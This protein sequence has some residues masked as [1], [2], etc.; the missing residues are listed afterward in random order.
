MAIVAACVAPAQAQPPPTVAPGDVGLPAAVPAGPAVDPGLIDGPPAPAAPRG[1]EPQR[2]GPHDGP[3]DSSRRGH[4]PRRR[5]RRAGLRDGAGNHRLHPAR[6]RQRGARHRADRGVDHVRRDERLRLRPVV[7]LRAPEPVGRERDA[8]R[9]RP[10]PENDNFGAFFDA[11][12]DRRNGFMFYANPLGGRADQQFTNEGNPNADWNPV[13]DVRTGRFDGGWTIEMEIPFKTF[14]YRSEPPHVWG[15][16]LRRGVRRKN[17]YSYLT[18][19][20]IAAGGG[21]GSTG[22]FRVSAA[23]SLVGLEPPPAS[24]NVE[25]KP[26]AIGGLTTDLT[27]SP[28]VVD[29]R[30]GYRRPRRQVRHH[31]EPDRRLHP[32]HRLCAGRGGRAAGEPDP[33][34]RCSFPRSASSSSRDGASSA[35]RKGASRAGSSVRR[36]ACSG[37][38]SATSMCRSSSTA[39]RSA[40]RRGAWCPSSAVRG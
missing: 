18:W 29:E 25:I 32:E 19:L 3:G 40:W 22:I 36:P 31:P 21:S 16:Q 11:F 5:A 34:P 38:S 28:R 23:G 8:P 14:R 33:F 1:D 20:P 15:I 27:A 26:Y 17:E 10:A 12:Y 30:S 13:W 6:T 4:P 24:R 39:G 2:G 37:G 35:L 9:H 7:G